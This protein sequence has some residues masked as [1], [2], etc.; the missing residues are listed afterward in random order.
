[1]ARKI[2]TKLKMTEI[3]AVDRPA[4]SSALVTIMKREPAPNPAALDAWAARYLQQ[5]QKGNAMTN[6]P[7]STDDLLDELA[8]RRHTP[9]DLEHLMSSPEFQEAYETEQAEKRE[10]F[11]TVYR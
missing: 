3:S 4:Q 1:M 7:K 2:I 10:R 11:S 9:D 6:K 5:I 8:K